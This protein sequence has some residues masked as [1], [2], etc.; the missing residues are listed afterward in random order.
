M[1]KTGMP[2]LLP[3]REERTL[4]VCGRT[5]RLPWP[6]VR[7]F[8][9]LTG[10][11]LLRFWPPLATPF[12]KNHPQVR[13]LCKTCRRGACRAACR[14][15]AANQRSPVG[16]RVP[17][18]GLEPPR[19]TPHAPQTCASTKFRHFGEPAKKYNG[20]RGRCQFAARASRRPS[21]CRPPR[22]GAGKFSQG[23]G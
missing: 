15:A 1:E 22:P 14:E 8:N 10:S 19:V 13:R 2:G 5:I 7:F 9:D 3:L 23:M 17:K 16:R 21:P 4:N 11:W 6:S 12:F 20:H 18:G